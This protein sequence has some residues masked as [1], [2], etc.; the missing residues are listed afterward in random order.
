MR[1]PLKSV[2]AD[3]TAPARFG[4]PVQPREWYFV[5]LSEITRAVELLQAGDLKE[6]YYDVEKSIV[7]KRGV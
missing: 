6:Y 1:F 3:V 5:P 7:I 2:Q 4:N